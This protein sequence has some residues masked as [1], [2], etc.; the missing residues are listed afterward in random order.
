MSRWIK[1]VAL[2]M[3]AFLVFDVC[4]P[5]SCAAQALLSVPA[6]VQVNAH[7]SDG[8]SQGCQF[9]EDCF[10]CTHFSPGHTFV[11][12]PIPVVAFTNANKYESSLDGIPLAPYHPPRA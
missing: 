7:Q 1:F 4:A 12:D 11:L 3:L 5:E 9:E 8:S 6:Q 2:F 10:N